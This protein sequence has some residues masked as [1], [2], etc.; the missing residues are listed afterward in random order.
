MAQ[1]CKHAAALLIV[2]RSRLQDNV[3][4]QRPVWEVALERLV[5]APAAAAEP[6]AV[7]LGLEFSVEQLPGYRGHR[8]KINLRMRP[9][10]RGH[11]GSWVRSGISWEELDYP[12]R[13]HPA[14]Q[15]DL[16]LQVRTAAGAAARFSLPRSPWLS[17]AEVSAGFWSL[18]AD[19]E[20][21]GLQLL[22]EGAAGRPPVITKLPARMVLDAA[23]TG[24]ELALEPT[25]LVDGR[26]LRTRRL[27]V[28]R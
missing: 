24:T 17:L 5:R 6:S 27:R 12:S 19:A 16:L 4:D 10:R 1:D 13:S 23:R 2:A 14:E 22:V 20:R 18:L 25:I 28:A 7:Q 3:G 21:A 9:V 15:R 26:P 11:R 8:G